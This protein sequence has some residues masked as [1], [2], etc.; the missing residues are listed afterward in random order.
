MNDLEMPLGWGERA[1]GGGVLGV[2]T[3][4]RFLEVPAGRRLGTRPLPFSGGLLVWTQLGKG[5]TEVGRALRV[6]CGHHRG[7]SRG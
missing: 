2:S 5:P 7:C 1:P 4:R 3:L 6:K